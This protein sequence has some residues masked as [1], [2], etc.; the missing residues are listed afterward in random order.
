MEQLLAGQADCRRMG[1]QVAVDVAG[2]GVVAGAVS[3]GLLV[4]QLEQVPDVPGRV[5]VHL[6]QQVRDHGLQRI[7]VEHP[8]VLGEE[9]PHDLHG[10][11]LDLVDRRGSDWYSGAMCAAAAVVSSRRCSTST[12]RLVGS[13]RK[14]KKSYRSGSCSRVNAVSYT[15]LRAHETDS[16]L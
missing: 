9:A 7:A 15:H 1:E 6:A 12:G 5:G 3:V 8:E 2:P 16:Y 13:S 4:Q 10:E 14:S 11:A